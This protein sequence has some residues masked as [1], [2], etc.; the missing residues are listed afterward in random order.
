M[1]GTVGVGTVLFALGI[2]QIGEETA[3]ALADCF[4]DLDSIRRAPLLLFL[5]VPDVGR[6]VA[7]AIAAC[8][9]SNLRPI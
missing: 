4:G 3:K 7:K 5:Q 2:L 9:Y 1:G 6:E 8:G